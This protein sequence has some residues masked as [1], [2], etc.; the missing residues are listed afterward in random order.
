MS[1]TSH[2]DD[3]RREIEQLE[4][5]LGDVTAALTQLASHTDA[6]AAVSGVVIDCADHEIRDGRARVIL[7]SRVLV[8]RL[9]YGFLAAAD[10]ELDREAITRILWGCD[11]EPLRHA[12]SVKSSIWRLRSLLTPTHLAVQT[13]ET[14]YRLVL[15]Q[16]TV[17]VAPDRG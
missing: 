13:T 15:P 7:R 2:G 3:K 9:L 12:S 8:R 10:H 4:R 5:V 11:Y 1:S 14:G 17:L 6:R 16:G